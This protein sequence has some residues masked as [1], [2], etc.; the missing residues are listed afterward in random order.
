MKIA[1]WATTY[2]GAH[3]R[4]FDD[5]EDDVPVMAWLVGSEENI[6]RYVRENFSYGS[7]GGKDKMSVATMVELYKRNHIPQ[8]D[9]CGGVARIADENGKLLFDCAREYGFKKSDGWRDC[10]TIDVDAVGEMYDDILKRLP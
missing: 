10:G 1:I 9:G 3:F 2:T 8:W 7:D 5:D 4:G 6:T